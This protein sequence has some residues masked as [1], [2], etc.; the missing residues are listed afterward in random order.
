ML[1]EWD[2]TEGT[3]SY[4]IYSSDNP[5]SGFSED[6][7]GEFDEANWTVPATNAKRFYYVVGINN[8]TTRIRR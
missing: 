4:K 1:L 6:T 3:I 2:H 8:V 7:N 5:N